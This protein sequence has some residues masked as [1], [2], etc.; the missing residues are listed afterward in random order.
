MYVTPYFPEPEAVAGN[1][2]AENYDVRLAFIR[3]VMFYTW[4]SV[5]GLCAVSAFPLQAV[6]SETSW[7]LVLGGLLL[8]TA[9]RRWKSGGMADRLSAWIVFPITLVALGHALDSW[10]AFGH[11]PTI[12]LVAVTVASLYVLLCKRDL[13]FLGMFMLGWPATI[14]IL[15]IVGEW[16][17]TAWYGLPSIL[18]AT[19]VL[20]FLVYDLASLLQRRRAGEEGLAMVDIYR[21]TLN[22]ITYGFRVIHHWRNFKL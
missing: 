7:L 1:I 8:L 4:C 22:F 10:T 14:V 13:S 11:L 18:I 2:A 21:D 9:A 5:A 3:R 16:S 20:F 15:F 12:L 6:P 17:G 19:A